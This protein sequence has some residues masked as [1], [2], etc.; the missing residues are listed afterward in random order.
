MDANENKSRKALDRFGIEPISYRIEKE[1]DRHNIEGKILLF[2]F[3]HLDHKLNC[4]LAYI[5]EDINYECKLYF[6]FEV[7]PY[8]VIVIKK[9]YKDGKGHIGGSRVT[10][11]MWSLDASDIDALLE[12]IIV[13]KKKDAFKDKLKKTVYKL[14]S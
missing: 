13:P 9:Y 5:L 7:D 10:E 8:E 11:Y 3:K 1:L 6:S 2:A 12:S 4:Q 14:I